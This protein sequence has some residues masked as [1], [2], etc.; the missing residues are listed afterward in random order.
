MA[1]ERRPLAETS[2]APWIEGKAQEQCV[3][4]QLLDVRLAPLDEQH[5]PVVA[6]RIEAELT[7][8]FRPVQTVQIRVRERRHGV[9]LL[10]QREGGAGHALRFG[11]AERAAQRAHEERLSRAERT[12]EDHEITRGQR[13]REQLRELL[14][15]ATR[16]QVEFQF[17]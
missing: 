15:R 16:G 7:Q 17:R 11:Q 2:D 10:H 1:R 9:V 8:L 14:R 13:R 12:G 5:A 3:T 4:A 6:L